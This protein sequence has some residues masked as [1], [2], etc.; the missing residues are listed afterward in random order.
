MDILKSFEEEKNFVLEKLDRLYNSIQNL[1]YEGKMSL[2]KNSTIINETVQH[3]KPVLMNHTDL[4]NQV[5]FPFA[6]KHIP[7]LEPVINFLK[8]ERK[9]F[10]TQL[11]SFEIL[12]QEFSQRNNSFV[13]Y[14]LLEKMREKGI[15]VVC[16][17]R[18]HMQAEV[19]TVYKVLNQKLKLIEKKELSRLIQKRMNDK[20]KGLN[21]T[22]AANHINRIR[23]L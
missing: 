7:I 11:E 12:F 18:N 4:D 19:E 8:A 9:E 10:I 3:L 23:L 1:Y 20:K 2:Q 16:I 22:S 17:V 14:M 6:S 5:I 15:Y 13:N 21:I